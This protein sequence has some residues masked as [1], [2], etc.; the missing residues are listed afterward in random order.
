[1]LIN[2]LDVAEALGRT[3]KKSS[4]LLTNIAKKI[5]IKVITRQLTVPSRSRWGACTKIALVNHINIDDVLDYYKDRLTKVGTS[6]NHK[7]YEKAI[8]TFST[9]K[10]Y[11]HFNQ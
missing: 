8:I 3:K 4:E 11:K 2:Y 1:M 10:N 7:K 5:A 9:I 6:H